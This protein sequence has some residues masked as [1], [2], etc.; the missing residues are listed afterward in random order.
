[1]K[2][3]LEWIR[4]QRQN[5]G[6][7]YDQELCEI[8]EREESVMIFVLFWSIYSTILQKSDLKAVISGVLEQTGMGAPLNLADSKI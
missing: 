2:D 1:M 8:E 3:E 5:F 7:T 4:H 6:P